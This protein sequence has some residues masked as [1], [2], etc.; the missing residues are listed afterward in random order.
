[1]VSSI[2]VSDAAAELYQRRRERA[3]LAEH[4]RFIHKIE[5]APFQVDCSATTE[6]MQ[7]K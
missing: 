7:L 2:S 5:P 1:M 3:D 4:I 6:V